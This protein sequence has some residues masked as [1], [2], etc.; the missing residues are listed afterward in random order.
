MELAA[1]GH[2]DKLQKRA[3]QLKNSENLIRK[4]KDELR[5]IQ[6]LITPKLLKSLFN[7]LEKKSPE[8]LVQMIEA[9]IG[10]LRNTDKVSPG[11]VEVNL[12]NAHNLISFTQKT[13]MASISR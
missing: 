3:D 9:F 11:D 4:Q 10:L 1:K 7:I 12:I 8:K 6:K 13:T 5:R 2:N